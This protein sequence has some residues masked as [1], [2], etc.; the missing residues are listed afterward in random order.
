MLQHHLSPRR[1]ANEAGAR[2][3]ASYRAGVSFALFPFVLLLT[4]LPLTFA[5]A[6][7]LLLD[8]N[9]AQCRRNEDCARF[10]RAACDTAAHICTPAPNLGGSSGGIAGSV[11]VGDGGKPGGSTGGTSGTGGMAADGRLCRTPEGCAACPEAPGAK[12]SNACSDV[13][14]VPF[15]NRTR[16]TNLDSRGELKPL[17]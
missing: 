12:L 14:C 3:P 16:L 9:A 1:C 2:D 15:D 7:T 13:V 10:P 4:S 11:G 17:P 6:C 8:T 5:S